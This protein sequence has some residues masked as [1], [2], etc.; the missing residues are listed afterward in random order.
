M[1]VKSKKVRT[2]ALMVYFIRFGVALDAN[3]Q[4]HENWR[5]RQEAHTQQ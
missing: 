3:A 4:A 2:T 5:N 1:V